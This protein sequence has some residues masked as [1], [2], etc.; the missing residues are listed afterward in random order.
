VGTGLAGTARITE[1]HGDIAA[2]AD[3]LSRNH[4]GVIFEDHTLPTTLRQGLPDSD[5]RLDEEADRALGERRLGTTHRR[6]MSA[7]SR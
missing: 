2:L 6:S 1:D 4:P 7:P 3:P 5:C